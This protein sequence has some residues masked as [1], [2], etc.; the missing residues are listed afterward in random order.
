MY[1]DTI[2]RKICRKYSATRSKEAKVL[3]KTKYWHG[4]EQ[5]AKGKNV[6]RALECRNLTSL[7]DATVEWNVY[8]Y[9][10]KPIKVVQLSASAC[11]PFYDVGFN[12]CVLTRYYTDDLYLFVKVLM[13]FDKTVN[14][15]YFKPMCH[16]CTNL[17]Y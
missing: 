10:Y 7:D 14:C 1:F 2:S 8:L 15:L 5:G 12:F 17:I 13:F 9:F 4:K 11:N 16:T 6:R 3:A